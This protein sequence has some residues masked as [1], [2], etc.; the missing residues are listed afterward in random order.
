MKQELPSVEWLQPAKP[1]WHQLNF[2]TRAD[3]AGTRA[4]PLTPHFS[5]DY[6]FML[7]EEEHTSH[8]VSQGAWHSIEPCHQLTKPTPVQK[9]MPSEAHKTML[10]KKFNYIS[11]WKAAS[12]M[13]PEAATHPHTHP[14]ACASPIPVPPP[15]RA[16][17]SS[18][19]SYTSFLVSEAAGLLI[20]RVTSYYT[21]AF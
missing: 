6:V 19:A 13:I 10:Q 5:T 12:G 8:V 18:L 21:Q 4:F 3:V 16:C 17:A 1:L 9:P 14:C 15:P 7:S 20:P 2:T 11:M